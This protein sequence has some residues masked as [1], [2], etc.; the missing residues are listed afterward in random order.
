MKRF[1][2]SVMAGALGSALL[3]S[4]VAFAQVSTSLPPIHEKNIQGTYIST[5]TLQMNDPASIGVFKVPVPSLTSVIHAI[6]NDVGK[7]DQ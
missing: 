2:L 6:G 4:G 1:L 3:A 5:F 7:K